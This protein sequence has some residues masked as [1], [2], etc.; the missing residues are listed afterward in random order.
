MELVQGV[1]ITEYCDQCNLT[2]PERLE[3]FVTVCQAVQHAHQKGVIHRDIKPSNVLVAIHD[4][5]PTPKIID[6]GV[7]KAINQ[8]L[9]EHTLV[10]AFA[11]I[12]GTPL[13]MSPEQAEL[14]PLGVDTRSDI[15]S[16]GVLLYEL[17]IGTT[18]FDKDRLH[19]ASYDELRRII[20]EE[21]PPRPSARLS[22]LSRSGEP[23]RTNKNSLPLGGREQ[24]STGNST[25][26]GTDAQRGR[27]AVDA[28]TI[29]AHRR[30]DP[31]RL[32]QTVR[33]EL[34]WIVMK[35]LEKD[36]N[37]RY[38]TPN[39]LARDIERYLHD[40]PVQACPPSATY[41][42]KKFV[43]RNKIAAAFILLLLA[44]VAALAFSN[45]QTRRNERR[46]NVATAKAQA[47][48][49][50]LQNMLATSN[51]DEVKGADYTV[52]QLLDDFSAGLGSELASQPEVEA[53]IRATV[54]RAYWRLGVADAAES[55]LTRAL[56]LRRRLFG[57]NHESV[58]DSLVDY[59]WNLAEQNRHADAE[60]N[61]REALRIYCARNVAPQV[62]IHAQCA[63]QRILISLRKLD[64][65]EAV[66]NE[67]LALARESGG[68]FPDVANILHALADAQI[69][70]GKHAEA[71]QAARQA[72]EMHRR[73]HGPNHP[74]TGWGLRTLGRVLL[75]QQKLPEAETALREALAVFRRQYTVDHKTVDFTLSDLADVLE[76][77][78]T[79]AKEELA[80]VQRELASQSDNAASDIHLAGL[81]M[82]DDPLPG[83]RQAAAH[84][85]IRRAMEEYD[86]MAAEAPRD[87]ERGL[88]AVDGYLDAAKLLLMDPGRSAEVDETYRRRTKLLETLLTKFPDSVSL[89]NDAAYKHRYW[90][91]LVEGVS[92]CWPQYENSLRQSI[93]L[94][95]KVALKD[96]NVPELWFF[97]A[98]SCVYFGDAAWVSAKS[99]DAETAFKRAMEIYDQ[100]RAEIESESDPKYIREI[101]R[102]YTCVAYYLTATDRLQQAADYV[103]RAARNAKRLTD[104]T[105]LADS[106]YYVALVQARLGDTAGYRATCETI[107]KVPLS[108][109]LPPGRLRPIVTPCLLPGALEDPRV[110][111]KLAEEVL[112]TNPLN[113]ASL[114]PYLLGKALQRAGQYEQAAKQ[115]E[116]AIELYPSGPPLRT[117]KINSIKLLLAMT[118]WQLGQQDAARELLS[119]T[120]PAVEAELQN[121]TTKWNVRASIALLRGEAKALIGPNEAD[122]AVENENRPDNELPSNP[123][124]QVPEEK[125]GQ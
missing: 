51:P 121:P 86:R 87:Q 31:R 42:L 64:E 103:D 60:S 23:S 38:E 122:E 16:L 41:R 49:A 25:L 26:P 118:K 71:E 2:T 6:F 94:F 75:L 125:R 20:R 30:T 52:R 89:Q 114:G 96:P 58:A 120:L 77:Q 113:E 14:S 46:A 19:S 39:S 119:K 53:E 1:P 44:G 21:E 100:H 34:D 90:A 12:V 93:D 123:V 37:R 11:Q 78:G 102:L 107:V 45:V 97:L 50:L 111:I 33:G 15:Y 8:Q 13:Y 101:V 10:T 70:Q 79:A 67:A 63:L 35:C 56:A 105:W 115:L 48:S 106:L 27:R 108:Q 80:N 88:K 24:T 117:H 66:A 9:T 76:R 47:V 82:T 40:E 98:S 18:P 57:S 43:R 59:A 36:R 29:A 85:L 112:A 73:L 7:A 109:I 68:E 92:R 54:G 3:L 28:T 32:Q 83:T 81:L 110:P 116:K 62:V 65:A 91:F 74:E 17:L 5:L 104:P 55:Q 99:E 124:E 95:E 72:V 22:S 61:I 84:R 4:G 69:E